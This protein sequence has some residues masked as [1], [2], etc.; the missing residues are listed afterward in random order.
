MVFIAAEQV[1]TLTKHNMHDHPDG[2]TRDVC[3]HESSAVG[4]TIFLSVLHQQVHKR[5][6]DV[7]DFVTVLTFAQ[8]LFTPLGFLGTIYS[9]IVQ[10]RL[11]WIIPND[12]KSQCP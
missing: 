1:R 11:T 10:V 9:R 2:T 6:M 3:I 8:Q 5:S 12:H 4:I 7:G